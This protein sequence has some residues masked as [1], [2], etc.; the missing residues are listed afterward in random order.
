MLR[1][2][3][4]TIVLA[5][6]YPPPD[7]IRLN[8]LLE[9]V[10]EYVSGVKIGLPYV[11]RY[12]LKNLSNL[13]NRH[14]NKY[15]FIADLKLADI[16]DV[17]LPVVDELSEAG[18]Q[19]VVSHAFVG[20]KGALEPLSLRVKDLGM[21]LFLQVSLPHEGAGEVIDKSYHLIKNVLNLTDASGLIVPASKGFI[22]REIRSSFGKRHVI[23]ASGILRMGA[24]PGEGICSGADAE[25]VGRAITLSTDLESAT[26]E[27]ITS[28]RTYIE[29]RKSECINTRVS[30]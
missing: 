16:A 22:I 6:N 24:K 5:V 11:L 1:D 27:I 3:E 30:L 13:V 17:M 10:Y 20:Y 8:T 29:S 18:F 28:Q 15:Y 12:G 25:V 19:G 26:R 23:L 7:I 4:R 21:D 9:R 2:R 14:K